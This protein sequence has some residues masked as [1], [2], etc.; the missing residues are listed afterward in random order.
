MPVDGVN[1]RAS[2]PGIVLTLRLE[3]IFLSLDPRVNRK[4]PG[5]RSSKPFSVQTSPVARSQSKDVHA[6]EP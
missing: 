3:T 1:S 6:P 2:L 4:P 5:L